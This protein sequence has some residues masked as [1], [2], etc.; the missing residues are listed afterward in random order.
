MEI[1][2]QLGV[3][4]RERKQVSA[5]LT[6]IGGV[7]D[8]KFAEAA[9]DDFGDTDFDAFE[10]SVARLGYRGCAGSSYRDNSGKLHHLLIEFADQ[11]GVTDRERKQVSGELANA[12]DG[13]FELDLAEAGRDDLCDGGEDLFA[14]TLVRLGHTVIIPGQGLLPGN[15]TPH[16]CD[17]FVITGRDGR[18]N[19][20]PRNDLRCCGDHHRRLP[21]A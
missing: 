7:V 6:L 1:A 13:V 17:V 20:G 9:R 5:D 10:R 3:T 18:K 4:D 21:P 11:L 12:A 14:S 19:W 15:D 8:G 2:D 16:T